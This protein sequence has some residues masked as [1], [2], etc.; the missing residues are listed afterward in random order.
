MKQISNL[1]LIPKKMIFMILNKFYYKGL[2]P[3]II[4]LTLSTLIILNL[5]K[6]NLVYAIDEQIL[7]VTAHIANTNVTEA[8]RTLEIRHDAGVHKVEVQDTKM[9]IVKEMAQ[10]ATTIIIAYWI[11][12]Y[13][14]L[15]LI[16]IVR[17]VQDWIGDNAEDI[18][19]IVDGDA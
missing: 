9:Q 12:P 4:Y 14:F 16:E 19:D 2:N 13:A 15:L 1:N 6:G 18:V 3:Q 5:L 7:E 11:Y 17:D 8:E 10:L